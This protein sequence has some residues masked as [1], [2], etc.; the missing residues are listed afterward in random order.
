MRDLDPQHVNSRPSRLD[1]AGNDQEKQRFSDDL[2]TGSGQQDDEHLPEDKQGQPPAPRGSF[3]SGWIWMAINTLATI[4]IVF[5]NKALFSDP[6]LKLAQLTFATFHFLL[7]YLTLFLL[8]HPPFTFFTPRRLPLLDILP[9]SLAMSLNVILPNLSLAFSTV[10]FYQIARILLTPTVALLNFLL[11]RATLPPLAILAL[12][13]ACVGVGTVSYYD[14]LPS[15]TARQQH[16]KTTT[17]LG[18]AFA[19]AGTAASS[20]YTVIVA[21]WHRRWNGVSSM[22]L[23]LNQ[24]PVSAFLL[25]YAIPFVDAF[26]SSWRA[27]PAGRWGMV[28]LSGAFAA[29]INISQFFIVAKTGAVSSTVVG[30]VK[31]VLIVALGWVTSGRGFASDG[32]VLMGVVAAVGGIIAYSVVMLKEKEKQAAR[33][34]GR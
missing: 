22:Q 26:P 21:A 11:Y 27:V 29:V 8:S 1:H 18:V 12:I 14:S 33:R 6:S 28:L 16:V 10:T 3:I 15:A 25:L 31:T 17:A 24:A 13:P 23:L 20:L 32:R 7:T 5:I 19:L 34:G 4:G 30:H 2:E 9:L